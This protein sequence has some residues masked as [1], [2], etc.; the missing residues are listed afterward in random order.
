MDCLTYV[1]VCPVGADGGECSWNISC[2][3]G[4]KRSV[5]IPEEDEQEV[6]LSYPYNIAK[7]SISGSS[8]LKVPTE[9]CNT[10][11]GYADPSPT[12]TPVPAAPTPT[13]PTP[14]PTP[15]PAPSPAPTPTPTPI[16]I[17]TPT[18]VPASIVPPIPS[19][20][21]TEYTLTYSQAAQGWPSFYSF[22]P[23]IMI[24]MNQYFYSFSGGNLFQHNSD[25]SRNNF[26]GTQYNSYI[27]TVFN[28]RPL[29]NKLFKTINLES[30]QAWDVT[31]ETD[32]QTNGYIDSEW[33]EKKENAF[34][35]FIRQRGEIPALTGEY[36]M[37][38][39]NGIGKAL[40]WSLASTT[41]TV[42]FS[43]TPLVS[44]GSEVSVGD[45]LYF[46]VPS[47][48]TVELA[49]QITNIE[50]NLPAGIN[51]ITVDASVSGAQPITVADPYILF[52]KSAEAESNGLLGHYGIFTLTNKSTQS[53]ELFAVESEIMKSYP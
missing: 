19:P 2:C 9:S 12:P 46:S 53:T 33:F 26:Y 30:D 5:T 44:I 35:A 13:A 20:V 38:S 23:E 16:P 39:V 50:V 29:E 37:R 47:Y 3:D 49:G 41:L 25:L 4:I 1:L 27:T 32:I 34:F 52:I 8:Y 28:E 42:S 24:G 18:P 6:C 40:S 51:R 36:A 31:M 11:C 22:I 7:T 45:Y 10:S 14:S 21:T 15:S 48:T 17:P 43:I